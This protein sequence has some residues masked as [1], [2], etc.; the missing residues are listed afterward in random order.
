M[1]AG[2]DTSRTELTRDLHYLEGKGFVTLKRRGNGQLRACLTADGVDVVEYTSAGV[3][4]L[5]R[6]EGG[7]TDEHRQLREAR[8]RIVQVLGIGMP[9]LT[10]ERTLLRSINDE[11]VSLSEPALRRELA[12]LSERMLVET[13]ESADV[14]R[15]R[16]TPLGVDVVEYAAAAPASVSRPDK[17]WD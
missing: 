4:G 3:T 12:Y 7:E 5:A 1:R 10:T 16:L 17:Y 8:W 14:W 9:H 13:D 15:A 11:E 6:P 2:L